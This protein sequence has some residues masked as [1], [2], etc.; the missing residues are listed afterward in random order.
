LLPYLL[1]NILQLKLYEI[2]FVISSYVLVADLQTPSSSV[3]FVPIRLI[4]LFAKQA[5]DL[6]GV[7]SLIGFEVN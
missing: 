1:E 3:W 5:L 7:A 6:P 4:V 2:D